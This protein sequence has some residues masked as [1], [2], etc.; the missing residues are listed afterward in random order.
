MAIIFTTADNFLYNDGSYQGLQI[1]ILYTIKLI[2]HKALN[3]YITR[4]N[5]YVC[6]CEFTYTV[7]RCLSEVIQPTLSS[8]NFFFIK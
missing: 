1:K 4:P 5:I 7:V 3:I 6:V 8:E 2:S